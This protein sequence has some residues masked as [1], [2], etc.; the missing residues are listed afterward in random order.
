MERHSSRL[1]KGSL[2]AAA[3][4]TPP[5]QPVTRRRTRQEGSEREV[6]AACTHVEP[7]TDELLVP[8]KQQRRVEPSET[9][10]LQDNLPRLGYGAPLLEDAMF[11]TAAASGSSPETAGAAEEAADEEAADSIQSGLMPDELVERAVAQLVPDIDDPPHKLHW[12]DRSG[13]LPAAKEL[14]AGISKGVLYSVDAV[15]YL[16]RDRGCR[17]RE[18]C[19]RR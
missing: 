13:F 19:A 11:D 9:S 1:G 2:A 10:T 4:G 5:A 16:Q 7:K 15:L 8:A 17:A 12:G 3:H 14:T 18:V 6:E